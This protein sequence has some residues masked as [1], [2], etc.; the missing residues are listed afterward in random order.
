[1]VGRSG[2][3]LVWTLGHPPSASVNLSV[4]ALHQLDKISLCAIEEDWR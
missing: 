3:R 2:W 4:K 1:M